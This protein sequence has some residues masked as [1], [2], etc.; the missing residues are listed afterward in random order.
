MDNNTLTII[1]EAFKVASNTPDSIENYTPNVTP[2]NKGQLD[3]FVHMILLLPEPVPSADQFINSLTV[4][5]RR[6]RRRTRRR[7]RKSRR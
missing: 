7:S 5:G 4:G 1:R 2:E 3:A 6:S